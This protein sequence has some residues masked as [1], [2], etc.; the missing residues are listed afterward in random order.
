MAYQGLVNL[1]MMVDRIGTLTTQRDS[2]LDQLEVYKNTG[3]QTR[4]AW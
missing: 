2:I 1:E 3:G 4:E